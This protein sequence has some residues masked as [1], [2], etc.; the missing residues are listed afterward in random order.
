MTLSFTAPMRI[1]SNIWAQ[2][3]V[4]FSSVGMLIDFNCMQKIITESFVFDHNYT[5]VLC[6]QFGTD[7]LSQSETNQGYQWYSSESL[8]Q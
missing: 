7:F 8:T 1:Q 6:Y 3:Y 5:Q 2:K 4:K